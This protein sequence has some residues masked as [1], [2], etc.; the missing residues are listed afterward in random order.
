MGAQFK[1]WPTITGHTWREKRGVLLTSRVC[2]KALVSRLHLHTNMFTCFPATNTHDNL[3]LMSNPVTWDGDCL[4]SR[5]N[6]SQLC[7]AGCPR[8]GLRPE[9]RSE[10]ELVRDGLVRENVILGGKGFSYQVGCSHGYVWML[11]KLLRN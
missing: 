5:G 1:S 10:I 11:Q 3:T 8:L 4:L 6:S 2:L 7:H 9:E